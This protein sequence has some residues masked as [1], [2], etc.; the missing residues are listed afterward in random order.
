[1]RLTYK[2]RLKQKCNKKLIELMTISKNLYNQA[3]YIVRQEFIF[4]HKYLDYN[5]IEKMM[6][7]SP[8]LEGSIN[9]KL[10]PAQTSQQI[11]KLLDK[12]WISFFKAIED[13][14]INPKKYKAKPNIPYYNK[15]NKFLLIFTN[16]NL[17]LKNQKL[18]S[19]SFKINIKL[20][21]KDIINENNYQQTRIIEKNCA[22]FCEVIYN[23]IEELKNINKNNVLSIDLGIN[24]FITAVTNINKRPVIINGRPLK[25][26][27]QFYNKQKAR[28]KSII[29]KGKNVKLKKDKKYFK[30]TKRMNRIELN[31]NLFINNFQHRTSKFII[32]Y[33]IKNRIGK[34]CVG[35]LNGLKTSISTGKRLN[36]QIVQIPFWI[37]KQKLKYK[38]QLYGIEYQ[39]VDECYTSKCDA[40][41]LEPICKHEQYFGKR[42]K[43][44]LFQSI[45]GLINAD[46]NGALNILRKVIGDSFIHL[47]NSRVMLHP[48]MIKNPF[49]SDSYK[50]FLLKSVNS[51]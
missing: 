3:N 6:K 1:M 43:R 49:D 29:N 40:L 18:K 27:N 31:R 12:N 50:W 44:G 21:Q 2:F 32:D 19:K 14:K 24:N 7:D 33:C 9:Y 20:P 26:Y 47:I 39:E 22:L 5:E 36:Q 25:S 17:R 10:L 30:E 51:F 4:N 13:W 28:L 42:I 38:C 34:I 41:G 11:L 8:N 45:K 35:E 37:F 15:E 48:I 16:Q 46:V 23:K